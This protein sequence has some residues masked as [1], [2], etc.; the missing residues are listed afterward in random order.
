M[1][2]HNGLDAIQLRFPRIDEVIA[3][4]G[5]DVHG[6]P[7]RH[8]VFLVRAAVVGDDPCVDGTDGSNEAA[9]MSIL[10]VGM[11]HFAAD[12]QHCAP[13]GLGDAR[14]VQDELLVLG[15]PLSPT[16]FAGH[17]P[18]KKADVGTPGAVGA[19]SKEIS[20]ENGVA[21]SAA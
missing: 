18:V 9:P 16:G 14:G 7:P 4:G 12:A 15:E 19:V 1:L 21:C 11:H 2:A 6:A 8:P 5:N 20:V 17:I 13:L 3:A 10:T